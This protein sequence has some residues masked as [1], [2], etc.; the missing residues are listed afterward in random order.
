[1]S[2]F[3]VSAG[4]NDRPKSEC[5][6]TNPFA[7]LTD[8]VENLF[9]TSVRP[10]VSLVKYLLIEGARTDSFYNA[11][12]FTMGF[13]A[14]T[15]TIFI[16]ITIIKLVTFSNNIIE[17]ENAKNTFKK[18]V[19]ILVLL[20]LTYYFYTSLLSINSNLTDLF[21]NSVSTSFF[22][23]KLRGVMSSII[24]LATY[25]FYLII[26]IITIMLLSIR[27]FFL[28]V[29]VVFLPIGL[30]FFNFDFL[31][32]YGSLILNFLMTN[33]FISVFCAITLKIFNILSKVYIFD[34]YQILMSTAG[35]LMIDLLLIFA[36]SFT[37]IKSSFKI[38]STR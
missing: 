36:I 31:K 32:Q 15:S 30:I 12:L 33:M 21:F 3:L 7:C 5:G 28:S 29:G 13:S 22:E 10:L 38:F 6:L 27:Y 23:I 2:T 14:F 18:L 17:R 35:F 16:A 9:N 26:L 11:W 19:I 25:L 37:L 4:H 34:E 8:Y 1:M 24:N 20:P